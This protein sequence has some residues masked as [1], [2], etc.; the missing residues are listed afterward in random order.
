M[1]AATC[2]RSTPPAATASSSADTSFKVVVDPKPTPSGQVIIYAALSGPNGGI[3]RSEDTGKTWQ[4]DARRPGDRRRPRPG[5]RHRPR[6][7]HRYLRPGQPPGRLR[8]HPRHGRLHEPQPGPGLEPDARRHRQPADLRHSLRR[9]AQRQPGQRPDPQRRRGT[10]RPGR[11]RS[12]PATPPRTPSTKAGSTPSS[13]RPPAPS[14]GSSS[15]RTSARTGPRS[16]SPPSRTRAIRP[17]RRSPPTTSASA[18]Y[19]IIGS[20]QFP[21]GNYN[22][23]IAV[24]PTD[25]SVIYVG[26]TADGNETGLIRIDLTDHLGCPLAGRLFGQ[27]Q[28]RRADQA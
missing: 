21:Q 23:A 22:I 12:R 24:D 6:P 4:L 20:A 7:R 3:W 25:P 1:P 28:R 9:P 2:C 11:A 26:G 27:R 18:D 17:T 10:D 14:T 5:E 16:A 8:R 19:P 15:P 13:P